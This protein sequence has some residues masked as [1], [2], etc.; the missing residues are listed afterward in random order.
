[1]MRLSMYIGYID[2][3]L[4]RSYMSKGIDTMQLHRQICH[5]RAPDHAVSF[6]HPNSLVTQDQ[7]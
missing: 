3:M 2:F 4:A 1:M 5:G 6:S 7:V